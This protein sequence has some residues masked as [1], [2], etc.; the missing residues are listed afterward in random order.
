M[1][2]ETIR[3]AIEAR[4]NTVTD[5]GVVSDYRR[6]ITTYADFADAFTTTVGDD[7]QIRAWDIAW[8]S[9]RYDP[10]GWTGTGMRMRGPQTFIVRGYMSAQDSRATDREFSAL[11]RS[12]IVAISKAGQALTPRQEWAPVELR[13]N[14]FMSFEAPGIGTVLIHHCEIA[15]TLDDEEVV[16]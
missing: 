11:I 9:G 4:L 8:E 2:Y 7:R 14:G 1:S 3:D 13:T 6:S 10:M 5:I 15:I 16:T 12:V